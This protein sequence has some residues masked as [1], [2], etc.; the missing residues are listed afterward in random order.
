MTFENEIVDLKKRIDQAIQEL[1]IDFAIGGKRLRPIACIKAYGKVDEKILKAAIAVELVHASTLVHDDIMDEDLVR[2]SKPSVLKRYAD[3]FKDKGSAKIFKDKSYKYGVSLA[4]IEGNVLLAKAFE[5]IADSGFSKASEGIK[6]LSKAY[7]DVNKG[8]EADIRFETEK[9]NEQDYLE[10]VRL[11]T[12]SLF[13][14]AVELGAL[15][16]DKDIDVFREY[17]ENAAIAFQIH[18]DL[19]DIGLGQK[20]NTFGSDI[21]QGKKNLLTIRAGV[22]GK[23]VDE[24]LKLISETKAVE[25]CQDKEKEYISK[26]KD[27]GDEFF[28]ALADHMIK[29]SK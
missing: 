7:E 24:A 12:G 20:G 10:M 14:A 9:V 2:R 4:I 15:F 3:E 26:A 6:I 13:R 23:D 16:G 5:L 21:R 28:V 19:L 8:Q 29:R 22:K 27:I 1:G 25:Y 11:K 17:A 18:D